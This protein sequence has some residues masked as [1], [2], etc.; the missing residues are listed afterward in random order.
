[1]ADQVYTFPYQN[2]PPSNPIIGVIYKSSLDEYWYI[3]G[4]DKRGWIKIVEEETNMSNSV[5]IGRNPESGCNYIPLPPKEL[6][7]KKKKM[8]NQEEKPKPKPKRKREL[9]IL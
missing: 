3:Y 9:M 5:I 2:T 8:N 6:F 7:K 4:G 1:M